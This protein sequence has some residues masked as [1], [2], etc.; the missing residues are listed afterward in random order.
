M[1]VFAGVTFLLAATVVG[2]SGCT[3]ADRAPV[4]IADLTDA[5]GPDQESWDVEYYVGEGGAAR[6]VLRADHMARYESADSVYYVMD[7]T[8][9]T[10]VSAEVFGQDDA[11]SDVQAEHITFFEKARVYD[12]VG[13]VY[14]VT[15]TGRELRTEH[16]VW[17]EASGRIRAEGYV[18]IDSETEA[19]R[20]YGLD[21]D[22]MLDSFTLRQVTGRKYIEDDELE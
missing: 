6:A 9:D 2:L 20:G 8:A 22:E 1:K 21:A 18:Q 11:K 7:G 3:V 16:L 4:S 13:S 10:P 5:E 17:S 19:L 15:S 14:V 12:L